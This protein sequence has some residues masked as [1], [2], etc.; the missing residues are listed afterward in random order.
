MAEAELDD[1]I[2]RLQPDL[3]ARHP[4]LFDAMGQLQ[5]EAASA[6]L[7]QMTGGKATLTREEILSLTEERVRRRTRQA[8]TNS[9]IR[10]TCHLA[11]V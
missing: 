10:M 7:R 1:V 5:P 3:R 11:N 8:P 4:E 9:A 2:A 6:A